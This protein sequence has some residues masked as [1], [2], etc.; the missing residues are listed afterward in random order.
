MSPRER[1]P[2]RTRGALESLGAVVLGFESIVVFLGGLVVYGLKALPWGIEPW[3]GIVG[4]AVMAVAMVAVSG[5]LRHRWAIVA[6]WALQVILALGGILVPALAVV[7]LIFGGMWAY[8]TIKG[9][10]LDRA[11]ARR[12]ADPDLSNGE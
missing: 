2:R 11:N 8:A 12:A 5:L 6:G 4:G 1:R 10:A 3:W 7:A 9:A